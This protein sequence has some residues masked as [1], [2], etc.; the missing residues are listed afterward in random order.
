[1][2]FHF[3]NS[4]TEKSVWL[5]L[6]NTLKAYALIHFLY[7]FLEI[8]KRGQGLRQWPRNNQRRHQ[9]FWDIGGGKK[10][11]RTTSGRQEINPQLPRCQMPRRWSKT[12][13]PRSLHAHMRGTQRDHGHVRIFACMYTPVLHQGRARSGSLLPILWGAHPQLWWLFGPSQAC[14][15]FSGAWR[16]EP[17]HLQIAI[18]VAHQEGP[19]HAHEGEAQGNFSRNASRELHWP[20]ATISFY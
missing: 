16:D 19:R 9:T 2:N 20:P 7:V 4:E 11:L 18:F 6:W 5:N 15:W 17:R 12:M 1:M 3:I 10:I 13:R 14:F 8:G